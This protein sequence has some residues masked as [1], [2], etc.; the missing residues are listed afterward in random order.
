MNENTIKSILEMNS[1]AILERAN[2]EAAKVQENIEDPNTDWKRKRKIQITLVFEA[3]ADRETVQMETEVKTTLA[4]MM[5]VTTTVYMV[6]DD[7]GDPMIVEAVRQTPGQLDMDGVKSKTMYCAHL[8]ETGCA[9]TCGVERTYQRHR[10][11]SP[12]SLDAARAAELG[13]SYGQYKAREV[14]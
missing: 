14:V 12:L 8:Q 11:L 13:L 9:R 4:P 3:S 7:Q 2:R 5:P 1:G 6:R 10:E